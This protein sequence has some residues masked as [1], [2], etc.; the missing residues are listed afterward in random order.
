MAC[1][2]EE[3]MKCE[4]RAEVGVTRF[5]VMAEM[6]WLERRPE[7]G[8]L[9][10]AAQGAGRKIDASV[11]QG[12]LPGVSGAGVA[13]IVRWCQ[14]LRLC[15]GRGSLLPLGERVAEGD[16][17]PV[18]EQGV[19]ELW[20]T[21]HPL[22]GRRILHAVRLRAEK[23]ARLDQ[24]VDLPV[25]PEQDK[26][27]ASIV[28]NERFVLRALLPTARAPGCLIKKDRSKCRVRW[29]ID[30][31]EAREQFQLEGHLDVGDEMKRIQHAP[32]QAGIALG[33]LHDE[34]AHERLSRH[35]RFR[36]DRLELRFDGIAEEAQE[37]FIQSYPLGDVEIPGKGRYREVTLEDVP[38]GPHSSEDA[39]RWALARLERHLGKELRY[40]T[41][42]DVRC[43]FSKL[44][45][46]TPL[47]PLRPELP[48]HDA[49]LCTY[50]SR[51]S[52]FFS[53][54]AAVDLSP[55]ELGAAELDAFRV[56]D[57]PA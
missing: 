14:T 50:D 57:E 26:P 7:L 36:N 10:R 21:D 42:G 15:D 55:V 32:E 5:A 48:A 28:S 31:D 11:V 44:V 25:I 19:F 56:N 13:N 8:A 34:W 24:L 22:L 51:P 9:C 38:I 27:F 54:C 37:K 40:R 45:A 41:R 16:L 49:L 53:L 3:S 47:E 12:V 33:R 20:V 17:A 39:Q 2:G 46:Q 23:D 29:N 52:A 4:L 1:A 35:G 43:L 18:P 6:A 30:F